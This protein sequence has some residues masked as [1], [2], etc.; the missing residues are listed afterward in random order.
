MPIRLVLADDHPLIL[1]GLANLFQLEE[2]FRV[3]ASCT[4]GIQALQVVRQHLPDVAILDI[5]MPIMSGL[6]VARAVQEE[7]L[8][9]R[10]VLLTAQLTQ[11]DMREAIQ[12]GV[13]GVVLKEMASQLLIQCVRKVH[14]GGQWMERRATKQVLESLLRRESATREMAALLTPREIELVRMVAG[15]LRNKEIAGKLCISE[16]TVKVHLHNIYEKLKVEG[17]MALLRY[18]QEKGLVSI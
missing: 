8:P 6:K 5:R 11:E 13:Q 17:R 3:L 12:L 18:A 1:S 2:D 7:K 10:L 9:T 16:G 14:A 4:D 15:G